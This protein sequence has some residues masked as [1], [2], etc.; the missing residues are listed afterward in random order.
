MFRK[1]FY[2]KPIVG[3]SHWHFIFCDFLN[4]TKYLFLSQHN[5]PPQSRKQKTAFDEKL[6]K[7][8]FTRTINE[9]Y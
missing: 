1:R 4:K 7:L 6:I 8:Q 5:S 2:Y 9:L 3:N